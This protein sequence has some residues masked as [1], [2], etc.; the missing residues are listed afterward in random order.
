M[1]GLFLLER[2]EAQEGTVVST[3][4][5]VRGRAAHAIER[6]YQFNRKE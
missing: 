4:P 2:R 3:A 5:G 6:S 1:E